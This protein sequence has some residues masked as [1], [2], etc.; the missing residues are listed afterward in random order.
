M[1]VREELEFQEHRKLNPLAAFSDESRGRPRYEAPREEDVRT[2][3]QRDID[4]IVHCKAFRRL[5]HKTQVFLQPEGDHYRTRLTHTLEVTRIARTI[6][7]ALGLNEDLAEAI[8][9]GHDLGH[10][11][12]GHAGE[13]ALSRCLGKPFRHNEQSLRV[14]DHLENDGQ[15]L[16]L[17]YEV[18]M[19]IVGHT[20]HRVPETMEGQIVRRSDQI[21]YVNH[22]IDDAIRAGILTN[23]DIPREITD[24][25]GHTHSQRI[26]TFVCDLIATSREAG[27]ILLSPAVD[28]ALKTLRAFMF[29]R[30]Y[31]NPIAK[32]EETKAKDM[33]KRLFEY[34]VTHPEALPE[35]FHP[36][37][38]FDGMERTVCDYIAGMTDNYAVDKFTEIFIPVGWHI[39]G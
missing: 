4:R 2:C 28:Q 34:Y 19:G 13:D 26:D 21:A 16:N 38:S 32:A 10:T 35:D 24:I 5:M 37:L 8:G 9:M 6:T 33:L 27:Q 11:P 17:T 39:R 7:L 1:T 22:D 15:G 30:V 31:R 23:E 14:V 36:Q 29:D 20:G 3:Y 18:R 25:I 12:F